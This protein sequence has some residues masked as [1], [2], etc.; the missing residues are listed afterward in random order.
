MEQPTSRRKFKANRNKV[1]NIIIDDPK[2]KQK[3]SILLEKFL[4]FC[5]GNCNV[6]TFQEKLKNYCKLAKIPQITCHQF[7]HNFAINW[8]MNDG[9]TASLQRI[10][11]HKDPKMVNLYLNSHTPRVKDY[12][13]PFFTVSNTKHQSKLFFAFVQ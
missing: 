8:L 13:F 4:L 10:L 3:I 7:R 6:L 12:Q 1:K 9:D 5:S 11:R 2:P